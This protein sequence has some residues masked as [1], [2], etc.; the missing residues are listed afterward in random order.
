MRLDTGSERRAWIFPMRLRSEMYGLLL[1]RRWI[2]RRYVRIRQHYRIRDHRQFLRQI[3]MGVRNYRITDEKPNPISHKLSD[4]AMMWDKNS[5][6][7]IDLL[8][9]RYTTHV[10]DECETVELG[11]R[12]VFTTTNIESFHV[13]EASKCIHEYRSFMERL[14]KTNDTKLRF[15]IVIELAF[16]MFL[17]HRE[18]FNEHERLVRKAETLSRFRDEDVR[19]TVIQWMQHVNFMMIEFRHMKFVKSFT[20]CIKQIKEWYDLDY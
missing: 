1:G 5:G 7:S 2:G 10:R 9:S 4:F 12:R 3:G 8:Q 18:S 11:L 6:I 16:T 13:R 17:S 14:D 15:A 20:W 19:L